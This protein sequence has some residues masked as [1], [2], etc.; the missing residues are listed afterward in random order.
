MGSTELCWAATAR[1]KGDG[2]DVGDGV[3]RVDR[4]DRDDE[5]H[6]DHGDHGGDG[7]IRDDG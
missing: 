6:G 3:W 5:D 4:D 2:D 7:N 1:D